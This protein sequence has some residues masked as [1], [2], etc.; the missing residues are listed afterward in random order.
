[1]K[2]S[3]VYGVAVPDYNFTGRKQETKRLTTMKYPK[4]LVAIAL[5]V[6][7]HPCMN[8]SAQMNPKPGFI[9]TNENDTIFGTIDYRSDAKNAYECLFQKEGETTFR[10]YSPKELKGYRFTDNGI[11]YV[12]RTFPVDG[13]NKE[14]FAE[15]LLKGGVSLFRHKEND[16]DYY[17]MVDETGKVAT[18]KDTGVMAASPAEVD[19]AKRN[20]LREA[21]QIFAKSSKAQDHLWKKAINAENLTKITRDYDMEYCTD[22]GDCVQ[23]Q[24]DQKATQS[25]QVRLR[26]QA[27]CGIGIN[28]LEPTRNAYDKEN[29]QTMTALVPQ[30]GIGADFLFPRSE[31]HWSLQFLAIVGYW[32]LSKEMRDLYNSKE[33]T[34]SLKYWNIEGQIGG[35]YHFCPKKKVSPIVRGG[36]VIDQAL[37]P[38]VEHLIGYYVGDGLNELNTCYGFYLGAG[39]DMP[40]G[41][42]L[43]RLSADYK[44][45]R[46][47]FSG[48]NSSCIAICAGIRF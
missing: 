9:I 17:Y 21:S 7:L 27:S 4:Q 12:T 35:V 23:F 14:F 18:V 32:N 24:Y 48:L 41:S 30:I 20:T 3:F 34:S 43:L 29:N 31:Q 11:Y 6:V 19:R 25:I 8:A 28:S 46:S 2:R 13:Q 22:S 5:F 42:H 36:L 15:F 40:V 45:S 16:T 44:W 10:S 38:S 37:S 39:I 26:L 47:S 33:D 1:M